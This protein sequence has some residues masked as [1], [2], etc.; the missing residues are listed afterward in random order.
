MAPSAAARPAVSADKEQAYVARLEAAFAE[1]TSAKSGVVSNPTQLSPQQ[2]ETYQ[3]FLDSVQAV[4]ASK[5]QALTRPMLVRE[6]IDMAWLLNLKALGKVSP[7]ER[8]RLDS[9]R[10]QLERLVEN[11]PADISALATT[12]LPPLVLPYIQQSCPFP[13]LLQHTK[14]F[15]SEAK[16]LQWVHAELQALVSLCVR[17]LA[18]P[19]SPTVVR[20]TPTPAV[21]APTP[22]PLEDDSVAAKFQQYVIFPVS[23]QGWMSIKTK[24]GWQKRWWQL[25]GSVLAYYAKPSDTKPK[26]LMDMCHATV[27]RA[28]RQNCF[29]LQLPE[30]QVVVAAHSAADYQAWLSCLNEAQHSRR[31]LYLQLSGALTEPAADRSPARPRGNT[32]VLPAGDVSDQLDDLLVRLEEKVYIY[33]CPA[34]N[35][36]LKSDDLFLQFCDQCGESLDNPVVERA[37]DYLFVLNTKGP[38]VSELT[39]PVP[40]EQLA[41]FTTGGPGF[42][43]YLLTALRMEVAQTV[44]ANTLF[45]T[46][47]VATKTTINFFKWVES[48]AHFVRR[49][50]SPFIKGIVSSSGYEVDPA[51]VPAGESV[52]ANVK[53]VESWARLILDK[54]IDSVASTPPPVRVAMAAVRFV[55]ETKF[56]DRGTSAVTGLYFLRWLGPWLSAPQAFAHPAAFLSNKRPLLPVAKVLNK[57]ANAAEFQNQKEQ[58]ML[59]F[60]KFLHDNQDR[61][62]VFIA[63]LTAVPMAVTAA[64][65]A[66]YERTEGLD[67]TARLA[68]LLPSPEAGRL[69]KVPFPENQDLICPFCATPRTTGVCPQ[70][71]YNFDGLEAGPKSHQDSKRQTVIL[72]GGSCID[73]N[74]KFTFFKRPYECSKC[75]RMFC[76]SHILKKFTSKLLGIHKPIQVLTSHTR[77]AVPVSPLSN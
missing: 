2:S 11:P 49:T 62:N 23:K 18:P 55:T 53:N 38:C 64:I 13:A 61:F 9:T 42:L 12:A 26:G 5:I 28:N 58:Y 56:P 32:A 72:V 73:C 33:V 67:A 46:D 29:V 54:L 19:A 37:E 34:C 66:V 36:E 27:T 59:P 7:A 10:E 48:Y 40:A 52:A 77:S 17:L 60:N 71:E 22:T 15:C 43:E 47:S 68:A 69:L 35:S 65:S 1:L 30:A 20:S 8:P 31:S 74:A 25:K 16:L 51:V 39:A 63:E 24:L 6:G 50:L 70:C 57:L 3:E 4:A 21:P 14:S 76:T 44:H 45:R 75:D 41:L